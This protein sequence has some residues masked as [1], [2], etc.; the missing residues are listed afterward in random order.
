MTQTRAVK[1]PAGLL[2]GLYGL[3]MGL[4]RG[5]EAPGYQQA[6]PSGL[7]SKAVVSAVNSTCC[8]SHKADCPGEAIKGFVLPS[9]PRRGTPSRDKGQVDRS[10]QM[11]VTLQRPAQG[12]CW[13]RD[14]GGGGGGRRWQKNGMSAS[15]TRKEGVPSD[16]GCWHHLKS[17]WYPARG[18]EARM[19]PRN[20]F[21]G[22]SPEGGREKA[23]GRTGQGERTLVLGVNSSGWE[24]CSDTDAFGYVL[25]PLDIS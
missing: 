9:S 13:N 18:G 15:S 5:G 19:S 2:R 1:V 23:A 3:G 17:W 14:N 25:Q 11:H 24:S 6:S 10:S 16:L 20:V 7:H 22:L 21:E 4:K 12:S 8:L